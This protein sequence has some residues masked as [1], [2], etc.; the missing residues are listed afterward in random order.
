MKK[1]T[2]I[3]QYAIL[4][5]L[6]NNETPEQ[7]SFDLKIEYELVKKFVEKNQTISTDKP[8]NTKTSKITSKDLMIS[9]TSV[10]GTKSVSIMTKEASQVND[11]F[12]KNTPSTTVSRTARNAIHKPNDK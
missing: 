1:L 2:K 12:K 7:I 6:S 11:E 5:L 10:K 8:I 9:Q 4:H 3:Q